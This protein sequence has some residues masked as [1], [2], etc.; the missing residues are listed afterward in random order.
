[1]L[2]SAR[3][4][5]AVVVLIVDFQS[6]IPNHIEVRDKLMDKKIQISIQQDKIYY[7]TLMSFL[8]FSLSLTLIINMV[9]DP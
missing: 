2:S 6:V 8:S 7:I 1:M 4:F 5:K 3:D 9:R